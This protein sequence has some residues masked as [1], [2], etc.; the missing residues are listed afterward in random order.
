M[1]NNLKEI[2]YLPSIRGLEIIFLFFLFYSFCGWF[3]EVMGEL[4]ANKRFVNRGFLIGPYCPIYGYGTVLITIFLEAYKQNIGIVFGMSVIICGILEYLTSFF[5]EKIFKA[6]WWDYS[7]KKFNIN[8]RVCLETLV[9]FGVG[10]TLVLCVL[11]KY[12]LYVLRIIPSLPLHIIAITLF[13]LFVVDNIVSSSIISKISAKIGKVSEDSTQLIRAK[14]K[15]IMETAPSL[16]KRVL[17]AY[18]QYKPLKLIIADATDALEKKKQEAALALALK[19]DDAFRFIEKNKE[20]LSE[21][22][23][24]KRVDITNGR[25]KQE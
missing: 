21:L 18:P 24:K 13:T 6:R 9:P 22:L 2:F 1:I 11:N 8:G 25:K 3:I 14:V 5:M 10:G 7:D 17:K 12:V 19:K 23:E 16:F 4:I 20:E 15:E